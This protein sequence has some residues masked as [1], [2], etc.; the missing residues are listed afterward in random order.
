MFVPHCPIEFA[1]WWSKRYHRASGCVWSPEVHKVELFQSISMLRVQAWTDRLE[2]AKVKKWKLLSSF[3]GALESQRREVSR[4]VICDVLV[5]E[6]LVRLLASTAK[7]ILV[8]EIRQR[9]HP[10]LQDTFVSM[11]QVRCVA[12]EQLIVELDRGAPWARSVNRLRIAIEQWT[13]MLLGMATAQQDMP[14]ATAFEY[15]FRSD[16]IREFAFEAAE[17]DQRLSPMLEDWF[18]VQGVRRM[19][20]SLAVAAPLYPDWGFQLH[21]LASSFLTSRAFLEESITESLQIEQ[22]FE[23][24]AHWLAMLGPV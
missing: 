13:D 5:S 19:M 23:K 3:G 8:P 10:L 4:E 11:R 15:G 14:V 7:S 9:I 1:L 17:T 6:P 16:R 2:T 24:I 21:Q 18:L 20:R 22:R 12:L